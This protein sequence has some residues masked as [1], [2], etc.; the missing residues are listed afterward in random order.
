MATVDVTR[1]GGL[2]TACTQP[3]CTGIIVDGYCDVCGSPAGAAP[4]ISA[5]ATASQGS[6]ASTDEP[7]R[8]AVHREAGLP[9]EPRNEG[10][11]TACTQPGCAGRIV[12]RYCDVCGSPAGAVPYVP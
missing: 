9:A 6:L 7:N 1:N 5:A 8:T 10:L 12:D 2:M 11:N 3:G 4:L